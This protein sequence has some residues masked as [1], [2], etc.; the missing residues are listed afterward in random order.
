[1]V[2]IYV[3]SGMTG[4]IMILPRD[5]LKDENGNSVT[6]DKAYYIMQQDYYLPKDKDG[7]VVIPM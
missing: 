4:A 5:G 7:T 6:F 3:T 1:M 2:P